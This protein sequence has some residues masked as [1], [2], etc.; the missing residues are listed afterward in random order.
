MPTTINTLLEDFRQAAV[1]NR[2]LGDKF[3][4]LVANYLVTDRQGNG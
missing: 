1:S 4:R 2:D 3:E